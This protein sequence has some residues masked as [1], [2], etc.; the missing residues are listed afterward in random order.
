MVCT[1]LSMYEVS[2]AQSTVNHSDG[3]LLTIELRR[4]ILLGIDKWAAS[5][6]L[7]VRFVWIVSV[8]VWMAM[9]HRCT[10]QC[11][12]QYHCRVPR[13]HSITIWLTYRVYIYIHID[14]YTNVTRC[15]YVMGINTDRYQIV[16]IKHFSIT[17]ER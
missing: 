2:N 5:I 11:Q 10:S 14:K 1:R 16:E 7:S 6:A 17:I 8:C 12:C 4:E 15:A 9:R 13:M 3:S